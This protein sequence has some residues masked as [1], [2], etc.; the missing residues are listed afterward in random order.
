MQMS[1]KVAAMDNSSP[2]SSSD[3]SFLVAVVFL[4]F[5]ITHAK[6]QAQTP[7]LFYFHTSS[8]QISKKNV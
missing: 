7:F 3:S 6:I 2:N 5:V 8:Q 1:I 4:L